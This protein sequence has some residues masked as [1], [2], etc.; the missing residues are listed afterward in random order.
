ME[1]AG[2]DGRWCVVIGGRGFAARHLVT[3]LLCS[4]E[5]RVRVAD[6]AP[7]ITL[8]REEEEGFLGAALREGQAVYASADLRDKAQVARG[9]DAIV[10]HHDLVVLL[11]M[12]VI[13]TQ[14]R[15]GRCEAISWM[16]ETSQLN[17]T[18]YQVCH[19]HFTPGLDASIYVLVDSIYA[20]QTA[21]DGYCGNLSDYEDNSYG[22]IN[23][24]RFMDGKKRERDMEV[25]HREVEAH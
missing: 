20:S 25:K 12:W 19:T 23:K 15:K 2:G 13:G 24:G 7:A 9:K 1:A 6:L 8:D 18:K 11:D 3:M 10:R 21:G 16:S 4:D 22:G 5:W 14:I 17:P